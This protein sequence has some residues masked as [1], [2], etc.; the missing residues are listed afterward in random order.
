[1]ALQKQLISIPFTGGLN[2][3]VNKHLLPLSQFFTLENCF[4]DKQGGLRIRNGYQ[5]LGSTQ[6]PGAVLSTVAAINNELVH[7]DGQSLWG[8]SPNDAV[9]WKRGS[10]GQLDVSVRQVFG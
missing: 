4:Y 2:Q 1:M 3:K 7:M 10:L 9:W 8:W 5:Q 6:S